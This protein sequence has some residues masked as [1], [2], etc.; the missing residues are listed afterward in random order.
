MLAAHLAFGELPQRCSKCLGNRERREKWGCDD[1]TAEPQAEFWCPFCNHKRGLPCELCKGKAMFAFHD[2]PQKVLRQYPEL[3]EAINYYN[4]V[5]KPF[6]HLPSHGGWLDQPATFCEA[7]QKFAEI[8]SE[9]R[10][11]PNEKD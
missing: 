3:I 7:M 8:E 4:T 5:F 2:C 1:P 9:L 11:D 10:K 6:G